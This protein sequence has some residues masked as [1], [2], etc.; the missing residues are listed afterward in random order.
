MT[1]ESICYPQFPFSFHSSIM[2]RDTCKSLIHEKL[3]DKLFTRTFGKKI[4]DDTRFI[5][6]TLK[7]DA[8]RLALDQ[9]KGVA[10]F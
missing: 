10:N 6:R 4:H 3:R 7:I 1:I 9:Y 8:L 5:N 2:I